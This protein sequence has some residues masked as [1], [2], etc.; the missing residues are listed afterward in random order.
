MTGASPEGV[1][2][3]CPFDSEYRSCHYAIMLA[4]VACGY[5]PRSSLETNSASIPRMKRIS[6]ALRESRY[7]IHD[8][9]RTRTG[10]DAALTRFNMPFEFGMAFLFAEAAEHLGNHD[11]LALLP[12][13]HPRG[14]FISDLAGYDLE[15][16]DETPATIIPPVLA[17]LAT[18][19]G[20]SPV[21]PSVN[22]DQLIKLMPEFQ[23]LIEAEDF[24]WRG[25]LTWSRL[26]NVARDVV[27]SNLS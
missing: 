26:V 5:Q 20:H 9:S 18:R 12:G 6:T 24:R 16:H 17:W 13:T 4:V 2:I 8:L 11:W 25:Y 14:E 21:P 19:P 3:N 7:S 27:A 23:A 15:C 1:F 22:P 10:P